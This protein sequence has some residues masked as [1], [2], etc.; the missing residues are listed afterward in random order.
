[1]WAGL[2]EL[3]EITI[4]LQQAIQNNLSVIGENYWM[5]SLFIVLIVLVGFLIHL[6]MQIVN[7]FIKN[8]KEINYFLNGMAEYYLEGMLHDKAY[9]KRILGLM[10]IPACVGTLCGAVA[11]SAMIGC[12]L[13][14][15]VSTSIMFSVYEVEHKQKQAEKEQ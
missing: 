12:L 14:A 2:N 9:R 10:F 8:E 7:Q 3:K 1:M 6:I 11:G 5:L 13:G 4:A 15:L